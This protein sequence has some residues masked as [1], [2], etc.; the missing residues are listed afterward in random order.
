MTTHASSRKLYSFPGA[1][2]GHWE[3]DEATLIR[4]KDRWIQIAQICAD[5]M[6]KSTPLREIQAPGLEM[7]SGYYAKKANESGFAYLSTVTQ[8]RDYALG[9]AEACKKALRIYSESELARTAVFQGLT[10]WEVEG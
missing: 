8:M 9:Q 4:V 1:N 3:F 7:A 10:G 6:G 5:A 2:G